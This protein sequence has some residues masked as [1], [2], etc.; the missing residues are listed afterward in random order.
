MD[1]LFQRI[2]EITTAW[3]YLDSCLDETVRAIHEKWGG[4]KIEAELPSMALNRKFAYFRKCYSQI[5]N[6][7]LIFPQF[8]ETIDEAEAA[9]NHRHQIVHGLA[10]DFNTFIRTGQF[11]TIRIKRLRGKVI[12]THAVYS[13]RHLTHFR[14][15]SLRLAVFWG[16]TAEIFRMEGEDEAHD[17]MRALLIKIT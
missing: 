9:S 7:S 13:L 16:A 2:G 6:F 17:S 15:Y 12:T 4:D 11:G 3:A 10:E 5:P 8:A 1:L 14:N